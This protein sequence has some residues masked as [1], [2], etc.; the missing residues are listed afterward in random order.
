MTVAEF[1]GFLRER[2]AQIVLTFT[3][4]SEFAN[5]FHD[6]S[7]RLY[8]RSILQSLESLPVTYLHE[9]LIEVNELEEAIEAFAQSRTPRVHSP[10]VSRWDE[11]AA[12]RGEPSPVRMIVGYRLDMMIF[13]LLGG[14]DGER[15]IEHRRQRAIATRNE[16]LKDREIPANH[17]PKPRQALTDALARKI[18]FWKL[19]RPSDITAFGKWIYADATR[20]P[21]F[22]IAWELF[23]ALIRNTDDPL[24]ATDVWD[25]A[26]FPAIPYVD[27]ATFDRRMCGYFS[28]IAGRVAKHTGA[29]DYRS[30]VH[31][32]LTDLVRALT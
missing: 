8:V 15:L 27:H 28:E 6:V 32:N 31:P 1:A 14:E 20:C 25:N 10:Y 23:C 13:D 11:T 16:V 24:E 2:D 17:R 5:C 9:T 18:E 29:A 4:V 21:G 22:R 7:D 12:I 3:N 30:R 26:H 19:P